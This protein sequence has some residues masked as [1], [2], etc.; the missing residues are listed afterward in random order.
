MPS[1]HLYS[2]LE[3]F[4]LLVCFFAYISQNISSFRILF[5][6][7]LI[8][9]QNFHMAGY[10]VH[11]DYITRSRQKRHEK[12]ILNTSVNSHIAV[13]KGLFSFFFFFLQLLK[14]KEVQQMCCFSNLH[15]F[16]VEYLGFISQKQVLLSC[17]GGFFHFR[18]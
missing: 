16:T 11:L 15:F 8:T 5:L 10:F 18:H 1:R 6:F 17:F 2:S 3:S 12:S 7:F 14:I 13:L 9:S 4:S